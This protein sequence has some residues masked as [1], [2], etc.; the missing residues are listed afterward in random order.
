MRSFPALLIALWAIV[1]GCG[2]AHADPSSAIEQARERAKA[3]ESEQHQ[4]RQAEQ[5]HKPAEPQPAEAPPAA[6]PAPNPGPPPE[7]TSAEE[8]P[9]EE[10]TAPVEPADA[11]DPLAP[12]PLSDIR[13]AKF[14]ASW[15]GPCTTVAAV[16]G[17]ILEAHGWRIGN[18]PDCHLWTIDTDHHPKSSQEWRVSK[19]PTFLVLQRTETGRWRELER[20]EGYATA[21]QI[22]GMYHRHAVPPHVAMKRRPSIDVPRAS[23]QSTLDLLRLLVGSESSVS[24]RWQTDRSNV[25]LPIADA[26]ALVLPNP[27]AC[28][29]QTQGEGFVISFQA[30]HPRA[31]LR[32]FGLTFSPAVQTLE[33]QPDGGRIG[34]GGVY[35]DVR[36]VAR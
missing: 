12:I 8:Q 21:N 23:L 35:P 34:L 11:E 4:K 29:V 24:A 2:L 19:L 5:S 33:V 15:C 25:R 9:A 32:K 30:P 27:T 36:I 3:L 22:A 17:P 1:A 6:S 28:T 7:E 31:E 14:T 10:P 18:M 26:T 13:I 20:H 16:E